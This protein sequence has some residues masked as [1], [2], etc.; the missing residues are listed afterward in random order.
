MVLSE[1]ENTAGAN[2]LRASLM[3]KIGIIQLQIFEEP[4]LAL[5]SFEKF[6]TFVAKYNEI[7][8]K[9]H[10]CFFQNDSDQWIVYH[11]TVFALLPFTQRINF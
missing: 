3:M 4:A 11:F 2:K 8:K 6:N 7:V 10:Q 5:E 1:F 9:R